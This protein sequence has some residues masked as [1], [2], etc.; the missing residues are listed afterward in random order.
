MEGNT[1]HKR[2]FNKKLRVFFLRNVDLSGKYK[3]LTRRN[4]CLNTKNI[5]DYFNSKNWNLTT[6]FLD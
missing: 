4:D 6:Q 1:C 3:H 2:V 5:N